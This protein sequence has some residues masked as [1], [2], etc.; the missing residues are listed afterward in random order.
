MIST[1]SWII[2]LTDLS[3]SSDVIALLSLKNESGVQFMMPIIFGSAKSN[4][5][6]RMR[7]YLCERKCLISTPK[8]AI[9]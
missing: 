7:K 6:L 4:N 5:L 3:I 1:P 8:N 2:L 9:K